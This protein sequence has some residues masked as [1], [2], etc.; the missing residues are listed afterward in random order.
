[1]LGRL[2]GGSFARSCDGF[3][4]LYAT[5]DGAAIVGLVAMVFDESI[6]FL[7]DS[8]Q[9]RP[10]ILQVSLEILILFH[11]QHKLLVFPFDC[12]ASIV[13]LLLAIFTI[14]FL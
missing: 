3:G 6:D 2:L 14:G 1:M 10:L 13:H 7:D 5:L 8:C 11:H 9:L 12:F 4:S